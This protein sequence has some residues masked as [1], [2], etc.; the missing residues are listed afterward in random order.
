[1]K[2]RLVEL[3]I[4]SCSWQASCTSCPISVPALCERRASPKRD[5]QN[6]ESQLRVWAVVLIS[7]SLA[8]R[9]CRLNCAKSNH[10]VQLLM[11]LKLGNEMCRKCC[12]EQAKALGCS[13]QALRMTVC[14]AVEPAKQVG[15]R[16]RDLRTLDDNEPKMKKQQAANV[17]CRWRLLQIGGALSLQITAISSQQSGRRNDLRKR[18]PLAKANIITISSSNHLFLGPLRWLV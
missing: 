14:A 11:L 8:I 17:S 1:M 3:L 4:P 5:C 13:A 6:E 15:K 9:C 12:D 16:A 7:V 18:S 10:F 2:A